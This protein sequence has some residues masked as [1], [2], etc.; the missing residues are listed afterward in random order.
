MEAALL[1]EHRKESQFIQQSSN[2]NSRYSADLG[3]AWAN[4]ASISPPQI[5]R[6]T[7]KIRSTSVDV[8][9]IL[10]MLDDFGK[11]LTHIDQSGPS[12]FKTLP[13]LA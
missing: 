9:D 11:Q 12:L 7:G 6:T 3:E 1:P 8:G 10:S 4:W 5:W 2:T 13:I